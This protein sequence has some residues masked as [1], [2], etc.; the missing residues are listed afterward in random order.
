MEL[1]VLCFHFL[2]KGRALVVVPGLIPTVVLIA[3]GERQHIAVVTVLKPVLITVC[4]GRFLDVDFIV[5]VWK[6]TSKS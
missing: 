2:L 3:V 1:C 6:E 5:I 4:S